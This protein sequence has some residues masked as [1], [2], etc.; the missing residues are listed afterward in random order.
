MKKIM[1][2]RKKYAGYFSLPGMSGFDLTV[3]F[4]SN[5]KKNGASK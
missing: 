5:E 4:I 3:K 1:F 2:L